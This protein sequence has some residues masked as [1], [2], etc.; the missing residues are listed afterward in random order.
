MSLSVFWVSVS[1]SMVTF[2]VR[3]LCGKQ[4][5]GKLM[6]KERVCFVSL[7]WPTE[8]TLYTFGEGRRRENIY[9]IEASERRRHKLV[10][11][12]SGGCLKELSIVTQ[13]A[14]KCGL[15]V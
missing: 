9:G 8:K 12:F 2:S 5:I 13:S 14:M 7:F 15:N 6:S 1:E 11:L 3:S 10:E 4:V